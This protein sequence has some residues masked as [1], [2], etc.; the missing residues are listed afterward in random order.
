VGLG[1]GLNAVEERIEPGLSSPQPVARLMPH[2]IEINFNI[3][4]PSTSLSL[5]RSLPIS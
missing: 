2:I 1:F 3:I 5:E 4:S